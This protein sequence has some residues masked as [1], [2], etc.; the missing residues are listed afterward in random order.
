[1]SEKIKIKIS[2]NDKMVEIPINTKEKAYQTRVELDL[3]LTITSYGI[4]PEKAGANAEDIADDVA[5]QIINM[6]QG[7]PDIYVGSW[8]VRATDDPEEIEEDAQ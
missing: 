5:T 6:F 2:P 4:T 1:M 3:L 8:G 7:D